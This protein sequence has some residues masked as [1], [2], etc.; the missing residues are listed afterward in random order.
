MNNKIIA[1]I[2]IIPLLLLAVGGTS[3]ANT[4]TNTQS[5]GYYSYGL[6]TTTSTITDLSYKG[7]NGSLLLA[8]ELTVNSS[9]RFD[10]PQMT[11][12][13][14]IKMENGTILNSS[15]NSVFLVMANHFDSAINLSLTATPV[16]V[17]VDFSSQMGVMMGG[18]GFTSSTYGSMQS[19]AY[20]IVVNNTT[21]FIISNAQMKGTSSRVTFQSTGYTLVGIISFNNFVK[22]VNHYRYVNNDRFAYNATTGFVSG[23]YSN[24]T[25]S[26]GMFSNLTYRMESSVLFSSLYA[27]GSGSLL[28]GSSILPSIPP[29]VPMTLGSLFVYANNTFIIGIHDN[30]VLQTGMIL[31]NGTVHIVLGHNITAKLV[32]TPGANVSISAQEAASVAGNSEN[33]DMGMNGNIQAG[34][35]ALLITGNG[36]TAYLFIQNANANISGSHVNITSS[37]IARLS[38]VAPPGLQGRISGAMSAVEKALSSGKIAAVISIND[39]TSTNGSIIMTYNTTVQTVVANI[40]SGK[41]T[42]D[43]SAETGHHVGTDVAIFISDSVIATGSSLHITFDGVSVGVQSSNGVINATSNTTASYAIIKVSGGMLIVF[44]IPHFSYHTLVISGSAPSV[45]SGISQADLYAILGIVAVIAVI[46]L[47]AVSVRKRS[48]K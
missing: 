11:G 6:N 24:F 17:R 16:P 25:F 15:H 8:T 46:S 10:L 28:T 27:N 1:L 30:K 43:L 37:T 9:G 5:T 42:I 34:P 47:I 39:G 23:K 12:M 3:F 44:H 13:N 36:I 14:F 45:T 4:S 38:L 29:N 41:V 2:A 33:V 20:S 26:D 32:K 31:E 19:T 18:M 48:R 21:F 22:T 7:D 35:Y 40:T